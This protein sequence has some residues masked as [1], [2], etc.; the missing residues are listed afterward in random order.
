MFV[1]KHNLFHY[2][3]ENER[4]MLSVPLKPPG[5]TVWVAVSYDFGVTFSIS[6]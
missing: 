6:R 3:E 1:R 4:R 5:P 2:A